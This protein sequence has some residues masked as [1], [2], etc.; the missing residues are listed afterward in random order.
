MRTF[1]S[2]VVV[3]AGFAL[4]ATG[5]GAGAPA[6]APAAY[7][8]IEA[9]FG[10]VPTFFRV[11]PAGAVDA[12]WSEF[13]GLWMT[14]TAIPAKYKDIISV[15]VAAQVPCEYCVSVDTK[16]A[17]FDGA[18][19]A[20]LAEGV[21]EA[22]LTRKWSTILNG[23][24]QDEAEFRAEFDRALAFADKMAAENRTPPAIAVT[25]TASARADVAANFGSVP[26]FIERVP[27]ASLAGSWLALKG[28]EF[29]G[30]TALP[31]KIKALVAVAVAAQIP[32]HY[33]L[34][35]DRASAKAYGATDAELDEAV[36][37]ASDTRQWSTILHG[38]QIDRQEFDREMD[39]AL[40][41]LARQA[42]APATN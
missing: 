12:L 7:A 11:V 14:E 41:H 42:A 17:R 28:M 36:A 35:A 20:E 39:A 22:A 5:A 3:L 16:F 31:A 6:T 18:T 40:A 29:S 10:S 1:R 34:Y 33:C 9:T 25:D 4:S 27:P 32:C 38:M 13:K 23:S 15:A 19:D 37:I 2:M 26:G 24:L 30:D 8:E 21:L